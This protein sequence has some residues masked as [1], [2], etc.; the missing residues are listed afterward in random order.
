MQKQFF[1]LVLSLLVVALLS[2]C[3]KPVDPPVKQGI[4]V[5]ID[6]NSSVAT[7][8]Q[9]GYDYPEIPLGY[10]RQIG[11]A[12]KAQAAWLEL[13]FNADFAV[14]K[15]GGYPGQQTVRT[16]PVVGGIAQDTIA[17]AVGKYWVGS[18][19]LNSNW[20]PLFD[21]YGETEVVANTVNQMEL[22]FDF[23]YS[24]MIDFQ[25]TGLPAVSVDSVAAVD[26]D[27][28]EYSAV[29]FYQN[30]DGLYAY[31][32]LPLSFEGSA[33]VLELDDGGQLLVDL[34]LTMYTINFGL[35]N[36][37]D[38][39]PLAYQ[40]P[41]SAGQM[42]INASFG[43]EKPFVRVDGNDY[44]FIQDAVLSGP[45]P[46]VMVGPG[47][48]PGFELPLGSERPVTIIGAGANKTRILPK[49]GGLAIRVDAAAG[50]GKALIPPLIRIVNATIE[51][52]NAYA[53]MALWGCSLEMVNCHAVGNNN[54][55]ILL[56]QPGSIIVDH[57]LFEGGGGFAIEVD[58][59]DSPII[60]RNSIFSG[61]QWTA[62]YLAT[63]DSDGSIGLY[64]RN[65]CFWDQ[66]D[67]AWPADVSCGN[68]IV[69]DPMLD[70]ET[71][72]PQAGSPCIDAGDDG[73]SIGLLWSE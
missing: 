40:E 3:P 65:C 36:L 44:D 23:M 31:I 39:Y 16:I 8:D 72:M 1:G 12:F 10:Q 57:C 7:G 60:V 11:A 55:L 64:Y 15:G 54:S 29:T 66:V 32:E 33:L 4:S 24:Y 5:Y 62:L 51:G 52:Y 48:Y 70:W 20:Q 53:G 43:F 25:I 68:A 9:K 41:Q 63:Y 73:N 18:R 71:M 47:R 28:E 67:Q 45:S 58:N 14:G 61:Y 37:G 42:T 49:D 34:P 22:E 2:G 26:Q 59:Y 19:I 27:N 69:A 30:N 46:V 21:A 13:T 35:Y 6:L 50:E 38:Y 56:G 17:L